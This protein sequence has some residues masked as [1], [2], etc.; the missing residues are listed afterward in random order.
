[1]ENN[2]SSPINKS[3]SFEDRTFVLDN[4]IKYASNFMQHFTST[5][6]GNFIILK[7]FLKNIICFTKKTPAVSL[8]TKN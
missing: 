8:S 4:R 2:I 7:I 6:I 1:M 3:S 5:S